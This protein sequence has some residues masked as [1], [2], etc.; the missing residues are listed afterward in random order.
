MPTANLILKTFSNYRHRV[1]EMVKKNFSHRR[2]P[3]LKLVPFGKNALRNKYEINVP[4]LKPVGLKAAVIA[5][6]L[7]EFKSCL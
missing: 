3:I 1:H 4:V 5:N 2:V 6:I 7:S